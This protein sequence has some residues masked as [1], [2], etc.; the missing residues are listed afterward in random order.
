VRLSSD[1]ESEGLSQRLNFKKFKLKS[2][3]PTSSL[4]VNLKTRRLKCHA[5]LQVGAETLG[6]IMLVLTLGV[7]PTPYALFVDIK[8]A[9]S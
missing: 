8:G 3:S 5:V 9:T 6:C 2:L 4:G 1:S 7:T